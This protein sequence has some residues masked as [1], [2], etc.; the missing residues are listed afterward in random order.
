MNDV[1][2]NVNENEDDCDDIF[3]DDDGDNCS[4]YFAAFPVFL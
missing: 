2:H 1:A 3:D 4:T